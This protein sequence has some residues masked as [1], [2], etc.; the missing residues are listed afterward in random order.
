[1][2]TEISQKLNLI[3]R[4][5]IRRNQILLA[6]KV[7]CDQQFEFSARDNQPQAIFR[8]MGRPRTSNEDVFVSSTLA[9]RDLGG[10]KRLFRS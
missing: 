1:M 9:V 3:S 2:R 6:H 10:G 5:H 8:L 4:V 7:L